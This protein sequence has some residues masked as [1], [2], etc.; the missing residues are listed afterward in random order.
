MQRWYL[1]HLVT[2][3]RAETASCDGGISSDSRLGG[4]QKTAVLGWYL[5]RLTTHRQ[6]R[7]MQKLEY[8]AAAGG[9]DD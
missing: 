4:E 7:L 1:L 3:R 8:N 6:P 2:Q 9:Y 5:L